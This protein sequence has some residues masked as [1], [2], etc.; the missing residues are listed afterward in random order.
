MISQ[1]LVGA[2]AI[3]FPAVVLGESFSLPFHKVQTY[4][5]TIL[6]P[7]K[8]HHRGRAQIGEVD[9]EVSSRLTSREKYS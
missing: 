9:Q 3:G 7:T 1:I 8:T 4:G 5:Q 2:F 6:P